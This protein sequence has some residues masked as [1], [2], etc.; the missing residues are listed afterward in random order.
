MIVVSFVFVVCLCVCVDEWFVIFFVDIF[1]YAN[2][3]L[4]YF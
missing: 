2:A 1:L 3:A 4:F